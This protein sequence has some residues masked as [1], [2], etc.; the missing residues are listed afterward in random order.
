[1]TETIEELAEELEIIDVDSAG[2][3]M[4]VID[5]PAKAYM[6]KHALELKTDDSEAWIATDGPV[7]L[8]EVE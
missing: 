4:G 3:R 8:K 1:M 6:T 2:C 5:R 7:D